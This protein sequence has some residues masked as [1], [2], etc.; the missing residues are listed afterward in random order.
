MTVTNDIEAIKQVVARYAFA[1]DERDVDEWLACWAGDGVLHRTNG[2]TVIGHEALGVYFREF[3]GRGRHVVSNSVIAVQ[4]DIA[5]HRSYV[6][7]FDRNNN[8]ALIMF[9]IYEDQLKRVDESW[10][11]TS[12]RAIPDA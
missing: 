8:H 12:R 3:Q 7:Y 2:Q 10:R 6:Q 11:F 9:G 4:G 1:F 5:S